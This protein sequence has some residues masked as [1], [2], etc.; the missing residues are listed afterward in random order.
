MGREDSVD[1]IKDVY[2]VD[3]LPDGTVILKDR[4][5]KVLKKLKVPVQENVSPITMSGSCVCSRQAGREGKG[6]VSYWFCEKDGK[7][8]TAEVWYEHGIPNS[9]DITTPGCKK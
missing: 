9:I 2:T 8:A 4:G 3:V 1:Q 7:F 6:S 5:Y